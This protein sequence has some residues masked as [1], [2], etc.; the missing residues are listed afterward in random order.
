MFNG[1]KTKW[2]Y[3]LLVNDLDYAIMIF[4]FFVIQDEPK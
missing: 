4:F 3:Q 1:K 2:E